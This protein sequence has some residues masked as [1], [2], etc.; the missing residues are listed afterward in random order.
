MALITINNCLFTVNFGFR[1]HFWLHGNSGQ[2]VKFKFFGLSCVIDISIGQ[3]HA[4]RRQVLSLRRKGQDFA[5]IV[6]ILG[7]I[8]STYYRYRSICPDIYSV[9]KLSSIQGSVFIFSL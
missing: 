2:L 3:I 5:K 8:S 7:P 1:Y 6:S 4:F 9:T